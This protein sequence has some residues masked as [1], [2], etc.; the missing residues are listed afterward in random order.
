MR[1]H[2]RRL[3]AK[4]G[5]NIPIYPILSILVNGLAIFLRRVSASIYDPKNP[6]ILLNFSSFGYIDNF[7][8]AIFALILGSLKFFFNFDLVLS[9]LPSA[10]SKFLG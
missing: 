7:G 10:I 4:H 1:Q 5:L 9:C 6:I 3:D 2:P 8:F